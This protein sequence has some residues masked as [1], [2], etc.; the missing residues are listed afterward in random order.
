M[1]MDSEMIDNG[2]TKV[3]LNGR[4]DISGTNEIETEFTALGHIKNA[5]ILVDL[6]DV[7]FIASIGMRAF[8][9]SATALSNRKG[10]MAL[11]NAQP[12]VKEA[13]ASAGIDTL[14]PMFDEMDAA[15]ASL[16]G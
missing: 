5:K 4:L 7:S 6:T 2:I 12:L 16:T 10:N 9:R 8:L 11:V 1:N 3:S 13:L 14:I 15:I